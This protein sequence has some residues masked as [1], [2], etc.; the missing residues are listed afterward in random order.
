[1]TTP[2]NLTYGTPGVGGTA[3]PLWAQTLND[4]LELIEAHDHTSGKGNPIVAASLDIDDDLPFNAH[5]ATELDAARFVD[6]SLDPST[7]V[8]AND[9]S[10][11]VKNGNL[12][13]Q[14]GLGSA[15]AVQ[16]TS[17]GA[18]AGTP[19]TIGSLAAPASVTWSAL[20]GNLIFEADSGD[21]TMMNLASG[22]I[23]LHPPGAGGASGDPVSI[24][25]PAVPTAPG[26]T[27]TLP[28]APGTTTQ[29]LGMSAAGALVLE[30]IPGILPLGAVVATFPNLT[31]AYA[32]ATT[33]AAD[34]R[35]FVKCNGG[36][37]SDATSPMNGQV[38]P[39]INNDV[40]LAGHTT[41]GTAGGANTHTHSLSVSGSVAMPDHIH[42][43][44]EAGG[45][46]IST[47][48]GLSVRNSST[49]G[50]AFGNDLVMR[51]SPGNELLD[52]DST[53]TSPRN[54][55]RL[56]GHTSSIDSAP[57]VGFTSTGTSGS[58]NS[59]PSYI[60]AVYI[61]RVK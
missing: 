15:A 29:A 32:C 7:P 60:T 34:S 35:G 5:M 53:T 48:T 42:N 57:S 49:P 14:D 52:W 3:G 47:E 11:F 55:T 45:A 27:I 54:S 25:A 17:A 2:M 8:A 21:G 37:I 30:T 46:A 40:F 9:L 61:M 43:L 41:A 26:Y 23:S 39:N 38:V 12:Y 51:T 59:R 31:G 36:T 4:S 19:G 18:V 24:Q 10:I 16:I 22:G 33:T 28:V 20:A 56:L 6:S 50:P 13:F 44:D 58:A 1:M